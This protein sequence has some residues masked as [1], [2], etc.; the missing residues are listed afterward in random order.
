MYIGLLVC[1]PRL[2]FATADCSPTRTFLGS[3]TITFPKPKPLNVPA[4]HP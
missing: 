1:R 4:T 3:L 2:D